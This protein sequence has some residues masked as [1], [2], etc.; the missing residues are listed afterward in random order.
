MEYRHDL[1][2]LLEMLVDKQIEPQ[3]A[4]VWTLEQAP[5]ALAELAAGA[6]PGKQV[7]TVNSC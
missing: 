2:M 3:I 6:L 7:I 1:A 4:A 5:G